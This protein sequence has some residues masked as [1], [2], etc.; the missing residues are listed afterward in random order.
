MTPARLAALEALAEAAQDLL[1]EHDRNTCTHENTKRGG[2]IWTICE[3]CGMK[4]ADDEGGFQPHQDSPKV[5]R[6]RVL[7]AKWRR[8]KS[9]S[10]PPPAATQRVRVAVYRHARHG[11]YAEWVSDGVT[12]P[13][14]GSAGALLVATIT[15]DIPLTPP[16]VPEIAASVEKAG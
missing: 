2:V 15:A 5:A 14:A 7:L 11:W 9:P 4:W 8:F 3:D 13:R 16:P 6:A 12:P 10:P 1:D